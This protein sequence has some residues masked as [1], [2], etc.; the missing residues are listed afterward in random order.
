VSFRDWYPPEYWRTVAKLRPPTTEYGNYEPTGA[1]FEA[2]VVPM[3]SREQFYASRGA[4]LTDRFLKLYCDESETG[5]LHH[6][7]R[8]S[9]P[10]YGECDV[11]N[12]GP[13]GF[14]VGTLQADLRDVRAEED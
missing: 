5:G 11:V 7:H 12:V 10:G 8:V 1:T 13:C 9:V 3:S 14:E 4:N 2:A 6:Y